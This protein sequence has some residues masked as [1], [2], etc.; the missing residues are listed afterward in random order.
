ML[1]L[2]SGLSGGAALAQEPQAAEAVE[3]GEYPQTF[4]TKYTRADGLPSNSVRAV[5]VL[6]DGQVQAGTDAGLA[7]LNDG[8]WTTL[9]DSQ[10][11]RVSPLAEREGETIAAAEG[12]L[13]SGRS[14]DVTE[15]GFL[16]SGNPNDLAVA[17]DTVYLATTNGLYRMETGRMTSVPELN[18]RLGGDRSVN[19]IAAGPDGA[20][21]VA[22]AGGLFEQK[23]GAEWQALQP[24]EGDRS[25]A[26]VDVRG[27]TYDSQG[28]FWFASPQGVGV[29]DGEEW[30]LYT[31]DDGLPYNDFTKIAASPDGSV[32]FATKVGA[33]HFDGDVWEYRQGLRWLPGDDVRDVAVDKDGQAYFATDGGVGFIGT[34]PMT[35][36]QKARAFE[37]AI[38]KYHRRTP[39]GY[40]LQVRLPA[41]GDTSSWENTDSDNDGLWTSMYGAG[42]CFAYAAT[43]DPYFKERAKKAFEALRFLMDVTQ[44]GTPPAQEGFVARTVLPASGP[45]PNAEAYTPEKDRQKKE[46]D[47]LWKILDPR[48]GTS[49]D[50]QWFWK[51]DTSSDELDGHYFFYAIYYDLLCETEEEK[52]AV[53]DVVQKL[54]DHLVRNNFQLVDHD[55]EPTRWAVYDPERF[56]N[57]PRWAVERGLNSLSMLS[58][59]ATAHHITGDP[60]FQ[61]ALKDLVKN[62]GYAINM[63]VPKVHMG[64][65]SGNQSDDEMAFMS[66]YNLMKYAPENSTLQE[67]A[68]YSWWGY[69]MMEKPEL[70]PLFNFMYASQCSGRSFTTAFATV[71]LTPRGSW[72]DQSIDQLKRYPLDRI[73]W[74][75]KNSHRLDVVPLP[76][77]MRDSDEFRDA[78]FRKG[79]RVDGKVLPIDERFV[80]HWNHDPWQLDQGGNGQE[81][82]D[83]ASYLLPYYM[84]L[85]HGFIK[86]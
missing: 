66:F 47:K 34:K 72:L 20:V 6:P 76:N 44:G 58:Y 54:T 85:Y 69:W 55:N 64:P 4:A 32:W 30:T 68:A 57:D 45:N 67:V 8:K 80:G 77:F 35:L 18:D 40:V 33:V 38:D 51:T 28:R 60:T 7:M 43:K 83:G 46:R 29:R 73:G 17:R 23:S 9:P 53:R 79:H 12:A 22:A 11:Y 14:G 31:G 71:N 74:R 25:W 39:Y 59:L 49:A 65:G 3:V 15:L 42:E 84:G 24:R 52:Q 21:A 5:L 70:N 56:N 41:P 36:M 10:G 82:A 81:L 78:P 13:Y 37:E 19:Q 16:P 62:H 26:P 2:A 48:W 86:E 75:L 1:A 50:G 61:Q 27:V 63:M